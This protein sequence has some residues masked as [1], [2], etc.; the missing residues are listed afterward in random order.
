M[1]N[2]IINKIDVAAKLISSVDTHPQHFSPLIQLSISTDK[3]L[4]I[5][6]FTPQEARDFLSQL[7]S[8]Q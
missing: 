5:F 3:R 2:Y 8:L 7:N 6:E 1:Q 4:F